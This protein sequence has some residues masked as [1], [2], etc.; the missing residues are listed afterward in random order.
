[1]VNIFSLD[2]DDASVKVP[3]VSSFTQLPVSVLCLCVVSKTIDEI[4]P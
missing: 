2:R 3:E 1:M 4:L